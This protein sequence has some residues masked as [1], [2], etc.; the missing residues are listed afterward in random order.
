[1]Y[2]T[3]ILSST[4]LAVPVVIV[5]N[6]TVGGT[7]KTPLI[8]ALCE[9]LTQK[10]LKV[11][12]VSRGYGARIEGEH[13]VLDNDP[14]DIS[15]DEPLLIKQ[16]TGCD[17]VT[18][19]NRV[20]A[21]RQ[22]HA[23]SACDLILSDDGMQHYRLGRDIE[24]AVIDADR[25]FGNGF[26]LPAGP[27]R[28][29]VSRLK[30]VDMQITHGA[31]DNDYQFELEI[32][33]AVNLVTNE[34]RQLAAFSG[35]QVHA[36]AGIGH[37][38]RFFDQLRSKGLTLNEHAFADHYRYNKTDLE[39]NDDLPVLMTEKDAVKCSLFQNQNLWSVP[40]TASL[41]DAFK[42]DFLKLVENI[43]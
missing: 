34:R 15:G 42:N 12:V 30:Q 10:G 39:F 43:R 40:A 28:E 21:A 6:I 4:R 19:I 11:G 35:S 5:G 32:T 23:E 36:V 31:T 20:A 25:K 9:M 1:M 29:P 41:S 18:G 17:V 27:L 3:G 7:G 16:R 37:P 14:V 2:S 26:C 8:I 38:Q 13:T 24:I 33:E 22:L